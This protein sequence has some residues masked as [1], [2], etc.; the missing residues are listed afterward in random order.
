MLA[1]SLEHGLAVDPH[2]CWLL[3]LDDTSCWA[4]ASLWWTSS[5]VIMA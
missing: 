3:S 1:S 5:V 2:M 4:S